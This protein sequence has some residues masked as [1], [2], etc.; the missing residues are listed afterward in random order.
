MGIMVV[1]DENK[2]TLD[3]PICLPILW[4]VYS[5]KNYFLYKI[6]DF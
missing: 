3:Y 5:M 6:T 4:A 1:K 2:F